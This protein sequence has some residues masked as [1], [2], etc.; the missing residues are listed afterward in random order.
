[1]EVVTTIVLVSIFAAVGTISYFSIV[2][3]SK[4]SSAENNLNQAAAA[5][6]TYYQEW[7][8]YPPIVS[9]TAP[10]V[11]QIEPD[12]TIIDG[13]SNTGLSTSPTILSYF[14]TSSTATLTALSSSGSCLELT[15]YAPTTNTPD[16][17]IRTTSANCY[18]SNGL[19][20]SSNQW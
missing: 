9:Q 6:Q 20:P 14:A 12:F 19:T 1:M 2:T 17:H 11:S 7:T 10:T 3:N 15:I 4:D 8:V 18:A 13:T 16:L 5:L